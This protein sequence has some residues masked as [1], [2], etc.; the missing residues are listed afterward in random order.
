MKELRESAQ[1]KYGIKIS[2]IAKGGEEL[3]DKIVRMVVMFKSLAERWD[4]SLR[5]WIM[6]PFVKKG[7]RRR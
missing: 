3:V 4:E 7:A 5:L 6:V 1:G 2:Y